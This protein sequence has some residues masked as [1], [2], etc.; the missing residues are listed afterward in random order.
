M[1]IS[2][3]LG[4]GELGEMCLTYLTNDPE[5][6]AE[7]M[8]ISGYD[9]TALRA[10]L[11]SEQLFRGLIDYFASNEPMMLAVCANNGISPEAFMRVWYKLNPGG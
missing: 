9:P 10:A 1:V 8:T 4:A 2:K 5:Q 7:F 3:G 6:L 11:G